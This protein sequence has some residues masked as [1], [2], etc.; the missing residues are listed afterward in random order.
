MNISVLEDIN[1]PLSLNIYDLNGKVIYQQKAINSKFLIELS[2]LS[3]GVY[4][5]TLTQNKKV[6]FRDKIIKK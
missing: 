5:Y 2:S 3:K 4:I 1:S 6:I